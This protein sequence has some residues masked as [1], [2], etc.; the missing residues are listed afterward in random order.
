MLTRRAYK[1]VAAEFERREKAGEPPT[2]RVHLTSGETLVVGTV[3]SYGDEESEWVLFRTVGEDLS[4]LVAVEC[5]ARVTVTPES[6]A[7]HPLGFTVE[8][9]PA[10]ELPRQ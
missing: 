8:E 6:G 9:R 10:P 4:E 3:V 2:V 7:K 5:V 1:Y